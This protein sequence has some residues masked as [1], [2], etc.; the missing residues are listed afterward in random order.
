MS[1]VGNS[2]QKKDRNKNLETEHLDGENKI[3]IIFR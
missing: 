3:I 2:I 1:R